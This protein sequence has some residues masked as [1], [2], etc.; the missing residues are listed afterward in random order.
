MGSNTGGL[1]SHMLCG[2]AKKRRRNDTNIYKEGHKQESRQLALFHISISRWSQLQQRNRP[3]AAWGPSKCQDDYEGYNSK[4]Y[5]AA[6]QMTPS[7]DSLWWLQ[8][9]EDVLLTLSKTHV[10][11]NSFSSWAWAAKTTLD[12]IP[13]QASSQEMMYMKDFWIR[14]WLTSECSQQKLTQC[15]RS[16]VFQ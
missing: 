10:Y 4:D 8:P 3:Q 9:L 13:T 11:S 16:T 15:G 6:N 2:A 12:S 5:G 14:N 1:R 7:G